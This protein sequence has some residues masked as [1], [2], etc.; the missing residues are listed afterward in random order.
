MTDPD[1]TR[2]D[3]VPATQSRLVPSR[4]MV[5]GG[6]SKKSDLFSYIGAGLLIGLLLDWV[7]GTSPLLLVLWTILGVAVGF[8][9]LW[10]GSSELEAE[11]RERGH[12]V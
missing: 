12:G 2:D 1:T 10:Q 4:D 11:G 3:D 7:F 6:F 8:Y 9:R 5:T